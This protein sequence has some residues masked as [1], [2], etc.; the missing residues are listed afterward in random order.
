MLCAKS[1]WQSELDLVY[2]LLSDVQASHVQGLNES[3]R[4]YLVDTI[5]QAATVA[6]GQHDG[7]ERIPREVAILSMELK[8]D[9]TLARQLAQLAGFDTLTTATASRVLGRIRHAAI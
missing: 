7:S 2:A 8:S 5:R 4:T 9:P 1:Q 3:I 6:L